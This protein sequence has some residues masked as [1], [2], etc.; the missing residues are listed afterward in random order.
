[1]ATRDAQQ[2]GDDCGE[3]PPQSPTLPRFNPLITEI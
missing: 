2:F 3:I 1:M